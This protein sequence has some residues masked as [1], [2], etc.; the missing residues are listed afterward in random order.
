LIRHVWSKGK[1]KGAGLKS[2]GSD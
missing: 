2:V 1:L